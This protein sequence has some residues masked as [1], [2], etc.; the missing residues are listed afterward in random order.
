MI[1]MLFQVVASILMIFT[2]EIYHGYDQGDPSLSAIKI[3][4]Q[5]KDF[6]IGL[7]YISRCLS[8][9]SAGMYIVLI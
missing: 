5:Y 3:A 8:G 1:C 2:L 9:W 4:L 7:F 6:G